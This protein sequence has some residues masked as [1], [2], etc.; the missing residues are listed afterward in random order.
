MSEIHGNLFMPAGT[1]C[2]FTAVQFTLIE[3][4]AQKLQKFGV[5]FMVCDC[6]A[7]TVLYLDG[8]AFTSDQ[9]KLSDLARQILNEEHETAG[10]GAGGENG[11]ISQVLCFSKKTVGVAII[12]AGA[13]QK[14]NYDYLKC[15]CSQHEI[16]YRQILNAC[17]TAPARDCE[18]LQELLSLFADYFES[19]ANSGKEIDI[20]SNELAQ[21]YEELVVLYKMIRNM[22]IS[23][24]DSNY[25]QMACDS[26]TELVNV[27]GI[28]VLLGKKIGY[29]HQHALAAGA[30]LI[31]IDEHFADLLYSRVQ[32]EVSSGKEALL[33]SEV[34]AP[35]RYAWPEW[36]RNIIAVPLLSNNKITGIMV[37]VNRI[38]KSDF[39]SID[40]KMFTSIADECVVFV[41]NG[42]LFREL[43]DLFIGSL[44]ALTKSIDAK[45]EYTRGH[46]ERVALISQWIAHRYA[47]QKPLEEDVIHKIYLTGLLHDIGKIGVNDAVLTKKGKLSAEEL[48]RIKSHPLIGANILSEIKLM[49]DITSGVLCH[50]EHVD[51]T[52]YPNGLRGDE[53]PLIGKI[54]MLADCFDAMTSRRSYRDAMSIDKAIEEIKSKLGTHFDEEIGQI[55]IESNVHKLWEILQDGTI[56]NTFRDGFSEYESNAVGALIR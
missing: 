36:I 22:K 32:Q 42:R 43:K 29:E 17:A 54:V 45:D 55:F 51:G 1:Q 25:L 13:P 52:G 2:G 5:N 24:P 12:D 14:A 23:E 4:F 16:D 15:F 26:I 11:A 19:T 9:A 47:E 56:E 3:Q 27:E 39:D 49:R 41:E 33:D 40:V 8:G 21:T 44:K 35:F 34:D 7:E 48:N 28:A 20:L 30:G 38:D 6:N 37:A 53:I 10:T 18:Y 31:E 46:S 50:H